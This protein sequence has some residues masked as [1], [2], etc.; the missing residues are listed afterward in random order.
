[1]TV[2]KFVMQ[3]EGTIDVDEDALEE[4]LERFKGT[5]L[6]RLED[7]LVGEFNR[8]KDVIQARNTIEFLRSERDALKAERDDLI[9]EI[10][11]LRVRRSDLTHAK[12]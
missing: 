2:G 3:I 7:E 4:L 11:S 10:H 8:R 12:K 6:R 5:T 9:Q 1:M